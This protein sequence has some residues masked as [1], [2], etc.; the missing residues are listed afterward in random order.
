[1]SYL[2]I[3]RATNI[4]HRIALLATMYFCL[5]S[6]PVYDIYTNNILQL[7]NRIIGGSLLSWNSQIRNLWIVAKYKMPNCCL[8]NYISPFQYSYGKDASLG[9]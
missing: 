9:R 1:M 6:T 5:I 8:A 3:G 4:F 2:N 7:C